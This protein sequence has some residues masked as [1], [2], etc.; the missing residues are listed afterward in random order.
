V[1]ADETP[2]VRRRDDPALDRAD[3]GD[4]AVVAG[5]RERRGDLGVERA[6]GGAA[7]ADRRAGERLLDRPGDAV[8]RAQLAG[9]LQLRGTAAEAD[10]LDIPDALP[11]RQPDRAADQ[12]DAEDGDPHPSRRARTAAVSPSSTAT[13]WSQSMQA[14]VIDWP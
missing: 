1:T 8:D 3:V 4:R 12:P 10:D 2:V 13:V 14:S 7:E 9:A 5:R 6:H 11:G